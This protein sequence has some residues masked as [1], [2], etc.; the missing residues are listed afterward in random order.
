MDPFCFILSTLLQK[1]V[2]RLEFKLTFNMDTQNFLLVNDSN[3]LQEA[4]CHEPNI[5]FS[6]SRIWW[7]VS[8]RAVRRPQFARN[9]L[10]GKPRFLLPVVV[11][12]TNRELLNLSKWV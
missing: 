2:T 3:V 12:I 9:L 7:I 1:F 4:V 5:N 6:S 10:C 11:E 8:F